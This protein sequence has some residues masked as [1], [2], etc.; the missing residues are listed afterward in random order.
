MI[1]VKILLIVI[2]GS[3]FFYHGFR[4]NTLQ[5]RQH[6]HDFALLQGDE[7]KRRRRNYTLSF[8]FYFSVLIIVALL[9]RFTR[10]FW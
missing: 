8:I 2:S 1:I 7:L 9:S 10:V 3:V 4:Y 6:E 5:I